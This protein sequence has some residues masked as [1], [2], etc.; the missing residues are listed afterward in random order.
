MVIAALALGVVRFVDPSFL[1]GTN[2]FSEREQ[3]RAAATEVKRDFM[4]QINGYRTQ[5]QGGQRLN[6]YFHYRYDAGIATSEIP[7]Y[8]DL[9][10]EVLEFMDDVD[11][12]QN[13][14]W[15]TLNERLC[16]ELASDFPIRAIS[17]QL[18]V[19]PDYRRGLP[20]EPGF[21]TSIHTIG[22]IEPLAI[23]GPPGLGPPSGLRVN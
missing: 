4:F 1:Q 11:A 22:A 12:A 6:M 9:R 14:Y 23:P 20:Y 19:Y 8:E 3:G 13:P 18:Q 7:N 21:H 5:N 15:E 10:A 16:T 2:E 17:C